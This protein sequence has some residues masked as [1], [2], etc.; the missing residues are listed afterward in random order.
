M[1]HPTNGKVVLVTGGN[2]GIGREMARQLARRG[3]RVIIGAR[4]TASGRRAADEV[5]AEG[6]EAT[7]LELDVSDSASVRAAAAAFAGH[8]D[9]LDVLVNNAGI[10]PDKGV[11]ILT[12]SR[13]Q[14][15]RT[16]QTNTFG[17]VE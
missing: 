11:D 14:L 10:Y 15:T 6:G 3:F 1:S 8:A 2:R 9:C 4:D 17:A 16:F 13:D 5:R 12:V 7:F